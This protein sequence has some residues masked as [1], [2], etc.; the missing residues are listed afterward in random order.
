MVEAAGIEPATMGLRTLQ[1]QIVKFSID[2]KSHLRKGDVLAVW[3]LDRLGQSLKHWIAYVAKFEEKGIG[4]HSIPHQY[5]KKMVELR[6]RHSTI[7]CIYEGKRIAIH[8]RAYK[9][10]LTTTHEHIPSNHQ[11]YAQW[12]PERLKKRALTTGPYT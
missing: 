8:P 10:S 1:T 12:T 4:F 3:S 7:E 2:P 5:P 11:A 9:L 6:V